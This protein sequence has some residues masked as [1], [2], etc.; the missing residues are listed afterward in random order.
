[1]K[2]PFDNSIENT[3]ENSKI[4]FVSDFSVEDYAGGAELSTS[5]LRES[6]TF[7]KPFFLRSRELTKEHIANGTQ[8]IWVFFNFGSMD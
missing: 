1:M 8:K 7:G 3:F 6:S 4:V 5:A 2:S